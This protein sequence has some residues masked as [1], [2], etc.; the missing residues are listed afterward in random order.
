M[1]GAFG[2]EAVTAKLRERL[3]AIEAARDISL[4]QTFQP[5]R[6][7]RTTRP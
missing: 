3:A 7:E 5:M 2:H 4:V 6:A 1:L